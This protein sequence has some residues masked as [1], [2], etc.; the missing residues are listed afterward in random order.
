MKYK[1]YLGLNDKDLK[2][3]VISTD[4][5]YDKVYQ[6]VGDNSIQEITGY[7]QGIREKTLIIEKF[8][9]ENFDIKQVCKTLTKVFNQEC[10]I[11]ETLATNGEF[12]YA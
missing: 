1:I 2:R 4:E 10:V 9:E 11:Y 12:V 8:E 7:Y 6:V 3:Q 5:A